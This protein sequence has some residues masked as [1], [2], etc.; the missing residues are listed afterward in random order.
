L[1]AHLVKSAVPRPR[2]PHELV[3]AG[4]WSFPSTTSALGTVFPFLAFGLAESLDDWARAAT[5]AA[6]VIVALLLGLSFV[7]LRVHYLSDVI[8]GLALGT[9][10]FL[11]CG[12][13]IGAIASRLSS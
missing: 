12:A 1:A 7:A 11:A 6:G 4:G 2:P 3:T 8:A 5:R 10:A 13:M 9:L